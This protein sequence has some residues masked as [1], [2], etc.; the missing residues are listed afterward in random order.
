MK[1]SRVRYA[2]IVIAIAVLAIPM[3]FGQSKRWKSSKTGNTGQTAVNAVSRPT[4]VTGEGIATPSG[5][6]YWDI[7][8]GK[9]DPATNGHAVKV[10]YRAWTDNG[11]EFASSTTDGKPPI[12]TLGAGQV[13]PGWEEGMQGMKVGGTRQLRIPP[14][15]AY[16]AAGAPP[17]VPPNATLI[18]DVVLIELP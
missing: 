4:N 16:G 8:T 2:L 11:K 12:F 14:N 17:L 6:R 7:Q 13:I 9:G 5:V 1:P 18:F 15:L 3:G 10:L